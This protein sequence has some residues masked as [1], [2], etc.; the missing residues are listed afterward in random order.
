[1]LTQF[2]DLWN[3]LFVALVSQTSKQSSLQW[4]KTGERCLWDSL[5]Y[6]E[7]NCP[8]AS[9][10]PNKEVR[11]L[12]DGLPLESAWRQHLVGRG[13][14]LLMGICSEPETN[15][16]CYFSHCL[17]R[18]SGN[19]KTN[20]DMRQFWLSWRPAY[21]GLAYHPCN[22]GL[23]CFRSLCTCFSQDPKETTHAK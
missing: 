17:N 5:L 7:P 15:I 23:C 11:G 13:G 16:W 4:S 19:Q 9:T 2:V 6:N 22:Y 21:K 20:M 12:T 1:M 3:A 10:W 8:K 18:A 14:H